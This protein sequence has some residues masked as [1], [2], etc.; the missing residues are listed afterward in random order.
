LS[1]SGANN[2]V[3]VVST[4]ENTISSLPEERRTKEE[5]NTILHEIKGNKQPIGSHHAELKPF[6]THNIKVNKG[7][8]IYLFT[9]GYA[10]QFGGE[11]GKKLKYKV[12]KKLLMLNSTTEMSEQQKSL[13]KF[14]NEWKGEMEQVDDVCVLG[15]RI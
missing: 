12:F 11:K 9:D 1:F 2:P 6:S 4:N 10:D 7:D 13:N 3:Y 5:Y 14:F 8:V 15:I